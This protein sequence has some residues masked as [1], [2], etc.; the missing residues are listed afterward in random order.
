MSNLGE[1][2]AALLPQAEGNP[3]AMMRMAALMRKNGQDE[4]ALGLCNRALTLAPDDLALAAQGRDFLSKGVPGWHFAIVADAVRNAAYDAALRRA[5]SP[6]MKVLEIGAGSGIL[7]MMAA[8]AGAAEVVTC[9]MNP[10]IAQTAQGIIERNGYGDRVRIFR[11]HS[12]KLTLAELGGRFDILVSE[13]VSNTLLGEDVLPAH[14]KAMRDLLKPGAQVIPARGRVRI[15]LAEDLQGEK[16]AMGAVDGFDLSPFNDLARPVRYFSPG[17]ERLGLR[18][19]PA[20]LFDFDFGTAKYCAPATTEISLRSQGGRVN[21]IAQWVALKMDAQGNYENHPAP[22]AESCWA[23]V[24]HSFPA[25][26]D[27]APGQEIRIA[28][29]HDRHHLTIWAEGV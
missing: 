28:G 12:D 9:E 2:L 4:E 19:A 8:R 17:H 6:G 14:E 7:A 23:L 20:D 1:G 29:S 24:F 18:S 25:S 10:V 13:I 15:A 22:G 3:L 5:I 27:T 26:I 21:G 11:G 16:H